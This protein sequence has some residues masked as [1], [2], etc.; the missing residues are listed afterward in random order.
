MAADRETK[1]LMSHDDRILSKTI[2]AG[3]EEDL[4]FSLALEQFLGRLPER[5]REIIM[6]R[7][8]IGDAH[9]KTLEEI[10]RTYQITRER[11]R[12][13]IASTLGFLASEQ[14]HPTFVKISECIQ[15]TLA[16]KNGIMK[17]EKLL[18]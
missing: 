17:T 6:A 8:G 16:G 11:V 7:F 18:R 4:F 13:V 2:K 15:S 5:S 12:Q 10:G 3:A 1:E 9:P 14:A